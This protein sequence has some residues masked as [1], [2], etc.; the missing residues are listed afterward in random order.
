MRPC[1]CR[2]LFW[3]NSDA[4]KNLVFG[5]DLVWRH[6]R[7]ACVKADPEGALLVF[8]RQ[9]FVGSSFR[10]ERGDDG[11]DKVISGHIILRPWG[12]EAA[13]PFT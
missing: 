7:A 13:F 10:G 8:R 9:G 6:S 4:E 3:V 5:E 12:R 1:H 2:L 11:L